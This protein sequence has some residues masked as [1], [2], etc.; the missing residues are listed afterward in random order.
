MDP[1]PEPGAGRVVILSGAIGSGKTAVA[2]A[3][4]PRLPDPTCYIEGDRFW[5]FIAT[6]TTRSRRDN[7]S[8]I[9]RAMTC[10]SLPFARSGFT[11]LLDF[12]IPPEY[13]SAVRRILKEIAFDYIVL[14]PSFDVCAR[15][16][17]ERDEG[18]ISNYETYRDFYR[19]FDVKEAIR[20]DESAPEQLAE[21]ISNHIAAGDFV[22]G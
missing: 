12:T 6:S 14:C 10:A 4:L 7:F 2:R 19:L 13:L 3:L 17:A 16:A 20:D 11:V 8:T 18:K 5:S 9:I 21:R 22:V 1:N 15:R